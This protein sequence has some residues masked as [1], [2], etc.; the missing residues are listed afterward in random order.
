[1]PTWTLHQRERPAGRGRPT[2][3]AR[4]RFLPLV[5]DVLTL[6]DELI[7]HVTAFRSPELVEAFGLPAEVAA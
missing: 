6:P 2:G 7:S 4:T 5:L 3:S 1:M